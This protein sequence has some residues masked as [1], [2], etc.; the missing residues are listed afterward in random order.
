[1][2]RDIM[3]ASISIKAEHIDRGGDSPSLTLSHSIHGRT[4]LFVEHFASIY[5]A[6]IVYRVTVQHLSHSFE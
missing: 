5:F 1:M 3:V 4:M 2:S 6:I